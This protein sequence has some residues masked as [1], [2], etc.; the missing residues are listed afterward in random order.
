MDIEV[1]AIGGDVLCDDI[2]FECARGDKL[3]GF[4]E[5]ELF[6]FAVRFAPDSWDGA[7]G[8][9]FVAAL[10]DT[11]VCPVWRG[12]TESGSVVVWNFEGGGYGGYGFVGCEGRLNYI[13]DVVA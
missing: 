9:F 6:W 11:E 12:D 3:F 5:D 7:E 2:E 4:G 1:A 10:A 13:D 8:A